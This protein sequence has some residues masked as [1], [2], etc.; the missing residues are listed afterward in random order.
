MSMAHLLFVRDFEAELDAERRLAERPP[1]THSD[2]ALHDAVVAAQAEGYAAGLVEGH[3]AG[4]AEALNRIEA[5]AAQ[6]LESLSGAVDVLLADRAAY[7]AGLE[8]EMSAFAGDL[9]ERVLPEL[10][11]LMGQSRLEAEIG[12]VVRRAVGSPALVIRLSPAVAERLE[13]GLVSTGAAAGQAVR[14]LP[15]PAL[16]RADVHAEWRHGR[17]RYSFAAICRSVLTMIR[18][19]APQH[20]TSDPSGAHYD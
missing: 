12:R 19:A 10:A 2:D 14:V 13:P 6:A 4:L 18:Q 20:P 7:R 16:D 3:A 11:G 9:A 17:S 1:A 8:A 15:D 5:Q